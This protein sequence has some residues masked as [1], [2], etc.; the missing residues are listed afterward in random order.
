MPGLLQRGEGLQMDARLAVACDEGIG[1]MRSKQFARNL[2]YFRG[3][4]GT[5]APATMADRAKK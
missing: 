2:I 4:T 1:K 3:K 5:D